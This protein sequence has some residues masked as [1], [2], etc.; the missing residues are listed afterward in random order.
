MRLVLDT[1]ILA[2]AAGSPSGPASDLFERVCTDHV[3]IV[4]S[5]LLEELAR[6]LSYDRVR[7]MHQ[8]NDA[9]IEEFIESIEL[10]ASIVS[11]P[12][13]VPRI[14]PHDPDDDLIVATAVAG[15]GDVLCTRN[16]HLFHP[17][18]VNYCRR[19]AIEIM[20]DIGMLK[21]FREI[22]A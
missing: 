13:S 11:L 6:V 10:G 20:D 21:R 15:K 9:G 3:L 18:V 7:R 1:N 17:N 5:E 22:E 4:S 8:M 14:V 12:P 2:R 19:H 16:K